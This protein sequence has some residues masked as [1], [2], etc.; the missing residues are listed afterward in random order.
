SAPAQTEGRGTIPNR[1]PGR[2]P[3]NENE[4]QQQPAR[5]YR[6]Q[7]NHPEAPHVHA[8]N[9][10]WIGHDA[11]RG[12]ARYRLE[13]PW[14]HGR[15]PGVTGPQ[16]IWRLRGGGRD[17]FDVGGYYFQ[18]APA[19]YDY[20]SDWMWDNDDIVIYPDPDH[21]GWYLAYNPR[22]GTYVHVLFLGT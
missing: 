7:P 17:R 4:N 2:A 11:G 14:E 15:F 1:T 6:D 5:S 3:G 20:V 19:D 18:V 10:R 8:E 12:D 9:D 21:D 16:H 22:L 13:R